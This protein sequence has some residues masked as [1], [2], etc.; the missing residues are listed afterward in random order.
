MESKLKQADAQLAVARANVAEMELRA[1]SEGTVL[2]ILHR[3]GDSAFT[4]YPEPVIIFGDL[5]KLRVRAE[6]DENYAMQLQTGQTAVVVLRNESR[7][8]LPGKVALV[9]RIM[10]GKTV[11]TKTAT[12]RKDLDVLQVLVDLPPGTALPVGLE[13]DVRIQTGK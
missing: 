8:E 7:T 13:V 9:K 2:E 1:P 6:V 4:A 10:G 5:T 3:A 11:F 12:E